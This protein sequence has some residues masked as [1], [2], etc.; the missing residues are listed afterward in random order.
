MT[1][2][3]RERVIE[4]AQ[5][6]LRAPTTEE[7]WVVDAHAAELAADALVPQRV[8]EREGG[9]WEVWFRLRHYEIVVRVDRDEDGTLAVIDTGTK[10]RLRVYLGVRSATVPPDEITARVGLVP[11]CTKMG[12]PPRQHFW[13][14]DPKRQELGSFAE[15]LAWLLEAVEPVAPR[16][17]AL[18]PAC[19]VVLTVVF[20]G[21]AGD[22]QF[23]QIRTEGGQLAR[24]AALGAELWVDI[25]ALGP[26]VADS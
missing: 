7:P 23:G 25:Y 8:V 14:F 15:K 11:T 20:E 5:A 2:S 21:W 10:P 17:A 19:E 1:A 18:R 4:L 24:I 6:E 26:R 3:E 16:I 22:A 12:R 13:A 9:L